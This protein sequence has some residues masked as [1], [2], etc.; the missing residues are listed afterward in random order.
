M[1]PGALLADSTL[2]DRHCNIRSTSCDA[3]MDVSTMVTAD[4]LTRS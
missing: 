3:A 1:Y 4:E 2:R